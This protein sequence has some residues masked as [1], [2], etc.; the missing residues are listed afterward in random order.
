MYQRFFFSFLSINFCVKGGS[1]NLLVLYLPKQHA[2]SEAG[3]PAGHNCPHKHRPAAS[4]IYLSEDIFFPTYQYLR[5]LQPSTTVGSTHLKP[6]THPLSHC[7]PSRAPGPS[8]LPPRT[9]PLPCR[10]AYPAAVRQARRR[11]RVLTEEETPSTFR[12]SIFQH[13]VLLISIFHFYNF[14]IS[15]VKLNMF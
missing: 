4:P 1:T 12:F 15:K 8:L 3:R 5:F 10:H 9:P 2:A 11:R 14:N 6:N 13:F 7:A